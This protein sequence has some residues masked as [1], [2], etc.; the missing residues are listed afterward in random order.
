MGGGWSGSPYGPTLATCQVGGILGVMY[1]IPLRRALVTG[2]DLPYPEGVAGAEVLKV[3][4]SAGAAEANKMGLRVSIGGSVVS[5]T[6]ALLSDLRLVKSALTKPF[7]T[8]DSSGSMVGGS[9][10]LGVSGVGVLVCVSVG[11]ATLVGL[12]ISYGA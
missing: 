12:F 3:G 10:S 5:V 2:W 9:M 4:D 7:K 6:Y 11:G 8:G 1:S